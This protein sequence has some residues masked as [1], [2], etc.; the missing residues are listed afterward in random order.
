MGIGTYLTI[1]CPE[2]LYGDIYKVPSELTKD[3]LS[4]NQAV[5]KQQ[6]E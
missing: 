2:N 5:C 6:Y 3:W 4:S 1:L